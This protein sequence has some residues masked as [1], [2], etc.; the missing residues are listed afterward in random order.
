MGLKSMISGPFLIGTLVGVGCRM[1]VFGPRLGTLVG[2]RQPMPMS[3]FWAHV[4]GTATSKVLRL[5]PREERA[6][7][8]PTAASGSRKS[9]PRC[10]CTVN[11]H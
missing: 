9:W 4:V 3:A 6:A 7:Q 10:A 8:G 2:T 11:V 5:G 1:M